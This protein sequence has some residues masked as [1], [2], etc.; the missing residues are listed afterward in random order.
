MTLQDYISLSQESINS[1]FVAISGAVA[2]IVAAVVAIAVGLLIGYVLKRILVEILQAI[3]F[4]KSLSNWTVYQKV[5]RSH[6]EIDITSFFGELLRWL[7][8]IVFLIPAIQSLQIEGADSVLQTVLGFIP[9]VIL[10]SLF[11]VLGFVIAWFVHRAI[12]VVAL[13][14]GNNPAHLIG[15]I[16]YFAIAIFVILQALLQLGVTAD[17]IRIIVIASIAAGALALGLG[18]RDEV[19]TLVKKFKEIDK[20][21]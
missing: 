21:R 5:L 14:A 10:A 16:A 15:N 6:E 11:L 12:E 4:E 2:N 17:I 8:I 20:G 18:A 13:V 19:S 3:N 7:A 9:N 1:F